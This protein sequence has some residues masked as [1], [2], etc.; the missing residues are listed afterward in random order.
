MNL[1]PTDRLAFVASFLIL[2][3]VATTC[4]AIEPP[5]CVDSSLTIELVAS[6][7]EIVTPV[8]CRF[9]S[10]GRLFVIE[11]HTHF[12]PEG[13][14]GPKFDR[15][16]LFDDPDGD[17]KLDRGRV[18]YE[19]TIKS[20]CLAIGRDDSIYVATRAAIIRLRDTDGDDVADQTETLIS[21]ET[22]A[23]YPHNGLSGLLLE[24]HVGKP[25]TLTFGMGE[26]FGD[27]YVLSG[28]DGSRQVGGGEG[29]NIF[30][31]SPEGSKLERVATGFWNPFGL[32]RDDAGRLLMV[33]ND[34]DAMPP[35]RIVNVVPH[36]DYGFQFRF[37][38]AGT[39]PLQAWNGELPGTLP[40]VAGTGEAPCAILCYRGQ[41]WVTSWG[42]NRIERYSPTHSG[43]SIKATRDIAVLGDSMFRPVDMAIA[44]DGSMYVTDWVDRSY[45][46][47]R[48]GRIWRIRF[49]LPAVPAPGMA[50]DAAELTVAKYPSDA[51]SSLVAQRWQTITEPLDDTVIASRASAIRTSLDDADEQVRQYAVRWA[52]ETG[53]KSLLPEVRAQLERESLSPQMVAMAAAAISFLE[54]GKVEKGGFDALTRQWLVSIAL[55]KSKRQSLRQIALRLVPP[56]SPQ[57]NVDELKS[58]VQ[59]NAAQ[60]SREA[61]RHLT[62]AANGNEQ[63]SRAVAELMKT[64]SLS[65]DIQRDLAV[66]IKTQPS[67]LTNGDSNPAIADLDAWMKLVG[68]GGDAENGWR[69]FFSTTGSKCSSCHA[70]D[71]RGAGVGPDLTSIA[72]NIDRRRILDSILNPSR[73]IGPMY[74]TWKV[75]T[76][77]GRVI[78]GLKLN[79]GGVGES[80]RYLLADSTTVDVA[81]GDIESQESSDKS[82]MPEGL[83]QLLTIDELRDLLAFLTSTGS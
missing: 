47:H 50:A 49:S 13:Y 7:P 74:T 26:N 56:Q 83:A 17:G 73:E 21:L 35:C 59:E 75:L 24:E 32:C 78:A 61:A 67:T 2:I 41:Y 37:G 39:H 46:V 5:K 25:A 28:S 38:R 76:T 60:L 10:K 14:P 42:D 23:D 12:P 70:K 43:P 29:G 69:I 27:T 44:P 4:A 80:N 18:F 22:K 1:R 54:T 57:W 81:Q 62:V 52:A 66:G 6:E 68:D 53:D 30:K 64:A 20:M 63:A 72:G 71:G 33:D 19:G 79:G 31:C 9:D 16:K 51:L 55:D 40:M 48:K 3:T 77:D 34:A 11:S 65:G 58:L 36:A 15:I 82:I 8:S 45:N